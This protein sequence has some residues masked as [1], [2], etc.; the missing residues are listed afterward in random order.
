MR[1]TV[2]RSVFMLS[3]SAPDPIR[4][5][6]SRGPALAAWILLLTALAGCSS[7]ARTTTTTT[8]TTTASAPRTVP[9]INGPRDLLVM[10]KEVRRV[11]EASPY[12]VLLRWWRALQAQDLAAARKAYA[13]SVDTSALAREIRGLSYPPRFDYRGNH[14]LVSDALQRSRPKRVEVTEHGGI[15]RLFAVINAAVFDKSD[16]N[17]VVF[18]SQTPVYF[19]L[20]QQGG[21]WKLANDDY[22]AQA[23]RTRPRPQG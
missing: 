3:M 11:G 15:V 21:Q 23:L 4:R 9:L 13:R 8:T 7:T 22:L 12:G 5:L 17:K 16:P 10:N 14:P 19:E 6:S 18:V 1:T 20:K 2:G